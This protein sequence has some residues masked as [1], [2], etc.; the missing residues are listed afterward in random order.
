MHTGVIEARCGFCTLP[1]K[2]VPPEQRVRVNANVETCSETCAE[3][4]RSRAQPR[5]TAHGVRRDL[6][7]LIPDAVPAYGTFRS[8]EE[9]H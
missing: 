4:L 2:A 8:R 9:D 5:L 1:L 6:A 3:I 7:R